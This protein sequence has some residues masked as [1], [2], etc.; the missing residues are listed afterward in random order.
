MNGSLVP[1]LGNPFAFGMPAPV[2]MGTSVPADDAPPPEPPLP[3]D[4]GDAIRAT[5]DADPDIVDAFTGG[6]F[7]DR[8]EGDVGGPY[9]VFRV[10]SSRPA[11]I[12]A[13]SAW[14]DTKI[15][16]T[17]YA[18]SAARAAGLRTL[19][20]SRFSGQR[21]A[22]LGGG[23]TPAFA[24]DRSDGEVPRTISGRLTPGAYPFMTQVDF[25][26]HE[27]RERP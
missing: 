14:Y 15:R 8:P 13:S 27:R 2:A 24:V 3:A 19:V 11:E 7:R 10:P 26:V 17:C 25:Q 9:L 23:T 18:D 16:F 1:Q 12:T 4:L 21:V 5:L 6:V 20:E 22:H